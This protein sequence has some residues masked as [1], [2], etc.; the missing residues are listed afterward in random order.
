MCNTNVCVLFLLI[1]LKY[2]INML[3]VRC[4]TLLY[5]SFNLK[6]IKIYIGGEIIKI[7]VCPHINANE[8]ETVGTHQFQFP[9]HKKV[10][11]I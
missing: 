10:S 6:Q 9:Y 5:W 1:I 7:N 3:I 11:N 4:N 2:L 8:E